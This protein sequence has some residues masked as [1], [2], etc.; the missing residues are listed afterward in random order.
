MPPGEAA[1]RSRASP[2][3]AHTTGPPRSTA[4]DVLHM[5]GRKSLTV[6][7]DG[8]RRL[9]DGT[10]AA[11]PPRSEVTSR[12]GDSRLLSVRHDRLA[13]RSRPSRR[14]QAGAASPVRVT[15]GHRGRRSC[16]ARRRRARMDSWRPRSRNTR[17]EGNMALRQP[18]PLGQRNAAYQGGHANGLGGSWRRPGSRRSAP[19]SGRRPGCGAAGRSRLGISPCRAGPRPPR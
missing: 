1:R 3:A 17:V 8:L 11:H 15:V 16:V 2:R 13:R 18:T 12:Y 5:F 4:H 6:S 10:R 19:S 9:L 7:A 14:L